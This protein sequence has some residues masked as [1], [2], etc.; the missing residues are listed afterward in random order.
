MFPGTISDWVKVIPSYYLVDTLHR[1][2]NFE[3]AWGDVSFNLL[4]LLVTG[5]ALLMLGTV[6]L[7]KKVVA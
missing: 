3:A 2:I 4:I 5:I 7:G 6:A 1:I